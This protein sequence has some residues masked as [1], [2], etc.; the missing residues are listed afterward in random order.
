MIGL[1]ERKNIFE[2]KK[3]I[4]SEV[5]K[6]QKI[7]YDNENERIE[8]LN[9]FDIIHYNI[10]PVKNHDRKIGLSINDVNIYCN[11]LP[12]KLLDLFNRLV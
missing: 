1:I 4:A 7:Y 5:C 9:C 6:I 11:E 3:M 10:L 2:N 8:Y 12:K